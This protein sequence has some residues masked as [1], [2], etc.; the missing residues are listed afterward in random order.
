MNAVY[1]WR[2]VGTNAYSGLD[3]SAIF[4]CVIGKEV[5]SGLS[6]VLEGLQIPFLALS[7]LDMRL[8]LPVIRHFSQA[9][10]YDNASVLAYS[11][12]VVARRSAFW[13]AFRWACCDGCAERKRALLAHASDM[14]MLLTSSFL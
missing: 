14:E 10:A 1:L 3:L 5:M 7:W 4:V 13:A 6:Y 9:L 12:S 11:A 8:A 2:I